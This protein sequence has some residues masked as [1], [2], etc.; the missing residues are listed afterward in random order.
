MIWTSLLD[1]LAI[2]GP[3]ARE[4]GVV[5]LVDLADGINERWKVFEP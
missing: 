2:D 1:F 4:L 3:R 5:D